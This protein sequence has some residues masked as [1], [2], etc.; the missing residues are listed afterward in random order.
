MP[1]R[2]EQLLQFPNTGLY[3]M[4]PKRAVPLTALRRA[5]GIHDTNTNSI[6]SRF[7]ETLLLT[8]PGI[9]TLSRL[10]TDRYAAAGSQLYRNG[11]GILLSATSDYLALQKS[12]PAPGLTDSLFV[13][14]GGL[15]RKIN[16][17][18]TVQNW[19]IAAPTQSLAAAAGGGVTTMSGRYWYHTTF[20]NTVTGNRSNSELLQAEV[21]AIALT[22][23]SLTNIPVSSDGQVNRR[24]IWRTVGDGGAFFLD[25]VL[26]DNVTTVLTDTYADAIPL[27]GSFTTN[28][29]QAIELPIDN[30]QP[31][32]TY[33]DAL[34]DGFTSFWLSREDGKKGRLYYSPPGRPEGVRGFLNITYDNDACQRIIAWNGRY[35][36]TLKG[37]YKIEGTDPYARRL[38]TGVP[39]VPAAN[40]R[41]VTPSP[42]GIFYQAS[43]GLR[44][45]NG[46]TS[47]LVAF[48]RIGSLFRGET[49]DYFPAFEGLYGAFARNQYFLSDGSRTLALNYITGFV[50]EL[51]VGLTSLFFEE[52]T[53]LLLGAT[54][55]GVYILEDESAG[56]FS[57]FDIETGSLALSLN[58]NVV[59]KRLRIKGQWGGQVITPSILLD[60]VERQLPPFTVTTD[61]VEYQIG[62][63][64]RSVSV[65]IQAT[66][67][68]PIVLEQIEVDIY[69]PADPDQQSSISKAFSSLLAKA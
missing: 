43:D 8:L 44:L 65:R 10:G 14:G 59:V 62:L 69:E 68:A 31:D 13:T 46:A 12:P 42:F 15:S 4:G 56:V 67:S 28:A 48:D 41:T 30:S 55:D 6:R 58:K 29:L 26:N 50:R 37:V 47:D 38:I 23:V 54:S 36:F 66:L 61:T 49:L 27:G 60:D 3:L 7:G 17:T 2:Q 24:E 22:Q 32:Q 11:I 20:M 21:L 51:G 34:I 33:S 64:A 18:G 52:D 1:E 16:S 35:V 57:H 40:A 63:P 25:Q 9:H 53:K 5:K 19:G 39:G 45:F